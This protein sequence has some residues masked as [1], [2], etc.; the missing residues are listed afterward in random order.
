MMRGFPK[1]GPMIQ[2]VSRAGAAGSL[3]PSTAP[4][5]F[6]WAV[7]NGA[8]V[9]VSLKTASRSQLACFIQQRKIFSLQAKEMAPR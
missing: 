8:L 2:R 6:R 3:I 5:V 4:E 9:Y 1:K 7:M